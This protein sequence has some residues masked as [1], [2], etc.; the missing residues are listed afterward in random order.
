MAPLNF[1]GIVRLCIKVYNVPL[2]SKSRGLDDLG[3]EEHE[4]NITYIRWF[5][6]S[7]SVIKGLDYP[8]T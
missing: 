8:Q 3:I 7:V 1:K 2:M 5:L 4:R 6:L